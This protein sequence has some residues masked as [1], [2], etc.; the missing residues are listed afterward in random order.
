MEDVGGPKVI[1]HKL[2]PSGPPA[3]VDVVGVGRQR[4]VECRQHLARISD[5]CRIADVEEIAVDD[6]VHAERDVVQLGSK[7]TVSRRNW[8]SN[9]D[10]AGQ[11]PHRETCRIGQALEQPREDRP[12]RDEAPA[13]GGDPG[14]QVPG[15][16]D[17]TVA[18]I[19]RDRPGVPKGVT[20]P[21]DRG[22]RI[23]EAEALG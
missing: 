11:K 16:D 4:F 2:L 5:L 1:V 14:H 8:T 17:E 13:T 12:F 23:V 18:V 10:A 9:G 3:A 21:A 20:Y 6:G 15:A 22:N 7:T 19:N